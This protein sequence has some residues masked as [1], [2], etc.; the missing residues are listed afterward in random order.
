MSIVSLCVRKEVVQLKN[1]LECGSRN[2]QIEN[3]GDEFNLEKYCISHTYVR[4]AQDVLMSP[5]SLV[6][7][8]GHDSDRS[9]FIVAIRVPQPV[10][11]SGKAGSLQKHTEFISLIGLGVDFQDDVRKV[12]DSQVEVIT[13]S[14]LHSCP[15]CFNHKVKIISRTTAD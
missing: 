4:L 11:Y 15:V 5:K 7:V 10:A 14:I 13:G 1:E 3:S 8:D 2:R 12:V 9:I 6:D